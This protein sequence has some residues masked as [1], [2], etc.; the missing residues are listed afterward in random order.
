MHATPVAR[1]I[2][3]PVLHDRVVKRPSAIGNLVVALINVQGLTVAA[4]AT[5]FGRAPELDLSK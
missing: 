5:Q 1:L 2:L 3:R 4:L